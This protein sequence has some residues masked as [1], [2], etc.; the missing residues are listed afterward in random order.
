[1]LGMDDHVENE[2]LMRQFQCCMLQ[3]VNVSLFI[4]CYF[5]VYQNK[6]TIVSIKL[7]TES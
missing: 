4:S 7:S 1:M 2:R 5:L 6:D 3:P